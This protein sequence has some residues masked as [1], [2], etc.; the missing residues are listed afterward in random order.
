M[1]PKRSTGGLVRGFLRI[2]EVLVAISLRRPIEWNEEPFRKASEE[3]KRRGCLF[4]A[5]LP[6]FTQ[7]GVSMMNWLDSVNPTLL[8]N[9]YIVGFAAIV[10][11]IAIALLILFGGPKI[12]IAVSLTIAVLAYPSVICFN[13]PR[14]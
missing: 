3:E 7:A 8:N 14:H 1:K 4:V 10:A 11:I 2:A 12:P 5:V 6:I 13:W 9:F